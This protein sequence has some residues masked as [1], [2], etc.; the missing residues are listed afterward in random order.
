MESSGDFAGAILTLAQQNV[1]ISVLEMSEKRDERGEDW[2]RRWT[3][4]EIRKSN[5]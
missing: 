1:V 4:H 2:W 5:L 3:K